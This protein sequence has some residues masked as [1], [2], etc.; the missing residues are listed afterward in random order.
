MAMETATVLAIKGLAA[1]TLSSVTALIVGDVNLFMAAVIGLVGGIIFFIKEY[2]MLSPEFKKTKK[3]MHVFVEFI[4]TIPMAMATTGIVIF[5]LIEVFHL[6]N[7]MAW[8]AGLMASLNYKHVVNFFTV[9]AKEY[10]NSFIKKP[11]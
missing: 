8:F 2:T 3:K 9:T 11:K 6:S 7:A 4:Y 5:G 10:I 1:G